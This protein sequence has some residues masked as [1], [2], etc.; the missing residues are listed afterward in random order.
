EAARR[1]LAAALTELRATADAAA[2]EW[3]GRAL[4]QER[5]V[6]AEQSGHRTLAEAVR[7]Q[8]ARPDRDTGTRTEDVRP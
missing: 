2:G 4:P 8:A 6:L 7:R 3:W 5:V 1:A